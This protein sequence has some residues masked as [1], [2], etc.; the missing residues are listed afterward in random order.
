MSPFNMTQ[1]TF[2]MYVFLECLKKGWSVGSATITANNSL[3]SFQNNRYL[4][5]D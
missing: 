4:V 5:N 2:W 1:E 3:I